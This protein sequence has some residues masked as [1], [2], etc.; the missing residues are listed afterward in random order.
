MASTEYHQQYRKQYWKHKKQVTFVIPA[1]EYAAIAQRAN[2]YGHTVG[3]Q[4]R[5]ESQAYQRGEFLPNK[6][7]R[8]RLDTIIRILR[9]I[10]NNINQ[11]AHH[12]NRMRRLVGQKKVLELLAQLERD[13]GRLIRS[14]WKPTK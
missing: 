12:S 2:L 4:Y 9:G 5:A 10:G 1:D 14:A 8:D 6:E 11:I 3:Q 13:A 7:I